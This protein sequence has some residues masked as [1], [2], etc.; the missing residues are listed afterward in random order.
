MSSYS[1]LSRSLI[2]SAVDDI[3]KEQTEQK[4]KET[5]TGRAKKSAVGRESRMCNSHILLVVFQEGAFF[6]MTEV[7]RRVFTNIQASFFSSEVTV[8]VNKLSQAL[9]KQKVESTA[10]RESSMS[11]PTDVDDLFRFLSNKEHQS[12]VFDE[13]N[14]D[15]SVNWR[16]P[17]FHVWHHFFQLTLKSRR[18][19]R[20]S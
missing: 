4:W 14:G 10:S 18:G 8:S 6:Q 12:V 19:F 7:C 20:L 13:V 2:Y 1:F 3:V 9:L 15:K 17:M 16:M 5:Y 11:L